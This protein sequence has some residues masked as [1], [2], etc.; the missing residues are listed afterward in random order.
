[1]RIRVVRRTIKSEIL[2]KEKTAPA[3][4]PV[5]V[6]VPGN[7]SALDLDLEHGGATGRVIVAVVEVMTD[8]VDNMYHGVSGDP[9][10]IVQNAEFEESWLRERT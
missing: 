5:I 4:A 2:R 6:A 8:A 9:L 3:P 10:I 7:G 1:M